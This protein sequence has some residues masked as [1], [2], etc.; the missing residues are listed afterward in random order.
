MLQVKTG[1]GKWYANVFLRDQQTYSP[2]GG[3]LPDMTKTY[4]ECIDF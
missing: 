1:K 2:W 4:G 3:E